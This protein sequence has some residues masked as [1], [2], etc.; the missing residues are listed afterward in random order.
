MQPNKTEY[1]TT[2]YKPIQ[3]CGLFI[4]ANSDRI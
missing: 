2:T 4:T 1:R 3:A